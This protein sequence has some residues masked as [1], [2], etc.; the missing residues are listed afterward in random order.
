[1]ASGKAI[2]SSSKLE[3]NVPLLK[4]RERIKAIAGDGSEIE[5]IEQEFSKI[6]EYANPEENVY[7]FSKFSKIPSNSKFITGSQNGGLYWRTSKIQKF[8]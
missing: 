1:M 6:P 2:R 7:N 4:I 5:Q 3:V 8:G